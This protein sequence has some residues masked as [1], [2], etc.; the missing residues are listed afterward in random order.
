MLRKATLSIMNHNVATLSLMKISI[1]TLSIMTHSIAPLSL[2]KIS[3]MAL[4]IMHT[5]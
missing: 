1:M 4:N 5:A 3:I 2:M